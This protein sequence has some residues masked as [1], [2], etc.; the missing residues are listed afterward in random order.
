MLPQNLDLSKTQTTWAQQLNPIINNPFI[1][2]RILKN[3]PLV[4]GANVINTTITDTLQG[5]TLIDQD[6]PASIYRSAPLSKLTLTLT[7][8]APCNIALWVF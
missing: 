7:A 4:S 3:I 5:W 8:S 6:A 2:G 1:N